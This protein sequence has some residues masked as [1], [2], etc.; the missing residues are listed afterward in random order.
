MPLAPRKDR[1]ARLRPSGD[2]RGDDAA[3]DESV[4][5]M[6][7]MTLAF[8]YASDSCEILTCVKASFLRA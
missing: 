4:A 3:S 1:N 6:L 8:S 5:P 2:E 7:K